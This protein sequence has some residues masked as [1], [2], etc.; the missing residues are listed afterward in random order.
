MIFNVIQNWQL[1]TKKLQK[2]HVAK[3]STEGYSH[4][5][6]FCFCILILVSARCKSARMIFALTND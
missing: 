5:F 1:A 4:A 3:T 2:A 6:Q